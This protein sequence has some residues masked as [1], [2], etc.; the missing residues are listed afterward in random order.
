M[1]GLYALRSVCG[2]LRDAALALLG[3]VQSVD[4]YDCRFNKPLPLVGFLQGYRK[5][6]LMVMRVGLDF[7][8][9]PLLSESTNV[10]SI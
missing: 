9:C 6:W 7:R 1:S 2:I 3:K 5:W 4:L 8:T 10:I